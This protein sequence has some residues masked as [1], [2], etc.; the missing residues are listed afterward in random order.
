MKN[1]QKGFAAVEGLLIAVVVIMVAGVGYYVWHAQKTANNNLNNAAQTSQNTPSLSGKSSNTT[2]QKYSL[3]TYK[4]PNGYSMLIPKEIYESYG[5]CKM[6]SGSYR[7]ENSWIPAKVFEQNGTA[8]ITVAYFYNLGGAVNNRDG[9]TDYKTCSKIEN[10]F[11][12]T[13]TIQTTQDKYVPFE[14][15]PMYIGSASSTSEVDSFVKQKIWNNY[16]VTALT[17]VTGKPWQ[18]VEVGLV[19]QNNLNGPWN[20]RVDIHY[21]PEKHKVVAWNIG[22]Y[23]HYVDPGSG[24]SPDYTGQ[25]ENSLQFN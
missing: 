6:A 4:S 2:T 18:N 23:N 14:T 9:T 19:D 11:A 20:G 1:I 13:N 8:Y 10:S 22:Q 7:P 25:I 24:N 16:K 21:Y 12:I 3:I 15:L 17:N 5:G